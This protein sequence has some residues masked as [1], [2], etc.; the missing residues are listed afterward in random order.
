MI[1][2]SILLILLVAADAISHIAL[3]LRGNQQNDRMEDMIREAFAREQGA[4]VKVSD[5]ER[6]TSDI[7]HEIKRLRAWSKMPDEFKF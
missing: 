4:V 1:P 6:G 5:Y 3:W 7:Q 2:A